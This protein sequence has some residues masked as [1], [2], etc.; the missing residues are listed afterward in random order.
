[1]LESLTI[2]PEHII[3]NIK[4]GFEVPKVVEAIATRKIVA[5]TASELGIT[6]DEAEIQEEG[7]KLRLEKK[8]V[9]AKDTWTWLKTHHLTLKEFEE[10]VHATILARKLAKHLFADKVEQVFY[11]NQLD[12]VAVATYQVVLDDKDLALELFYALQE[13]EITFQEI[14]RQYIQDPKLRCAGGYQ[15]IRHRRDFR[16]EIAAAV[17]AARPPEILKPMTTSK[18]V[19][20]IWVEEIIQPQLDEEL[21]QKII[22]ELFS[23]WLKQQ[24]QRI[25]IVTQ[26]DLYANL[27]P[28]EELLK[29][30]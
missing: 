7:D 25:E 22:T 1:M 13:S 9:T 19:H 21:R 20:L 5:E 15:G 6:V 10:L 18:G 23:N 2:S 14:A 4:L 28:Q 12:Y 30:A 27:Q 17:F 16:P 29:Q 3:H 8:L 11:E 26:L 24:I